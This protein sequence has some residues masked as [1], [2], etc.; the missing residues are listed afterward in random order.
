MRA[1]RSALA[2]VPILAAVTLAATPAAAGPAAATGATIPASVVKASAAAGKHWKPGPARYSVGKHLDRPIT[3][4]DGTVLRADVYYPTTSSGKEAS[5]KFPVLLTMTPYGK[6]VA[7]ASSSTGG[8]TGPN[9]YLVQRG[10]IDVVAD[11]RGTGDSE[12][13]FGLFDPVQDTDGATL[14]KWAAKRPHSNGKVGTYGAS[15]LGINQLLTA[16][17]LPKG[18]PLKAIF[19]VVPGNDLYKDTAFMGGLLDIEFSAFYLG[20]TGGLNSIGP[21]VEGLQNPAVL[22]SLLPAE[23]QHLGDLATFDAAFTAKTI[24]GDA[25]AYDGA[26]WKARNPVNVLKKIVANRIPAYLVGGEYDLFQRGEPLDYSGLQN[27]WAG[28]SVTAPMSANQ[29]TTGRYQLIDGPFTHLGGA[30]AALNPLMLEWFDTWLKGAHTGMGKTKTPLH[31]YDLGTKKYTEHAQYPFKNAKATRYYFSP[32]KKLTTAEPAAAGSDPLVWSP[33]GNPCGR[34][35]DQWS[36]GVASLVT[37]SVKPGT[38]CV[39]GDD[40]V[41][42]LGP[43]RTTYT[44]TPLKRAR[45]IAGPIDVSVHATATTS[46]TQWVAEVEDVAPDGT[47]TPL[48]E[49]ALLGSLRK[50]SKAGTWPGKDGQILQPG[51]TYS[52]ASAAAVTPGKLTRYDIDVFPTYATIAKGHR[53]RITLSTADTPHLVPT[54]PELARLAGGVYQVQ[55]GSS[56]VEIPLIG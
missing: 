14:V 27:A 49:G 16:A 39:D 42:Q 47:S 23:V 31:Y 2:V 41:G 10:Y 8:E 34:P 13:E 26:Y 45:T 44:T 29:K 20:L 25:S 52:K 9:Q 18:S 40:Q 22:A 12:G 15:Y 32:G 38:P 17:A 7:G 28:R 24:S 48:T 3:M 53:I 33:V 19:P 43:D 5:G 36:A 55:L 56:A 51:H 11:V 21:I 6:G 37:G 30:T 4:K 35:T 54:I 1:R 50:V 46:E